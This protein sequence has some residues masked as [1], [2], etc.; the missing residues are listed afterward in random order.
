MIIEKKV[1]LKTNYYYVVV[2]VEYKQNKQGFTM[3]CFK[4]GKVYD[5]GDFSRLIERCEKS[6]TY[7]KAREYDGE[8]GFLA[9]V[10]YLY[11][12]IPF[13]VG[14][15]DVYIADDANLPSSIGYITKEEI[16]AYIKEQKIKMN[17]NPRFDLNNEETWII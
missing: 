9:D 5:G 15:K 10:L 12:R 8:I 7:K 17:K 4:D 2:D 6:Y 3:L 1:K 16:N 13:L 14:I 11:D